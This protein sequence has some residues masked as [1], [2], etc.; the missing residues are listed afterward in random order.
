MEVYLV[1]HGEASVPPGGSERVL[2]DRGRD[3]VRRIAECLHSRDVAPA[4]ILHSTR[5][6]ARETAEILAEKLGGIPLKEVEGLAPEDRVSTIA[7]LAMRTERDLML[8][9]HLPHL[10][11]LASRLVSG[12]GDVAFNF[13]TA[14]ALSLLG[15]RQGHPAV[16]SPVRFAVNFLVRPADLPV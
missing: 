15:F 4:E 9:G 1:R 7:E 16:P 12:T 13:P 3:Q 8:V 14:A 6:R 2:T 5:I 10:D 11:L